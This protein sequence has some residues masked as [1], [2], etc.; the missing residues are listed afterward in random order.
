MYG[1]VFQTLSSSC[2]GVLEMSSFDAV[3]FYNT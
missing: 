2:F 3:V 1:N